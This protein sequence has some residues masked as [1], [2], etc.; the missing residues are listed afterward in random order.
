MRIYGGHRA[1][2]YRSVLCWAVVTVVVLFKWNREEESDKYGFL[3]VVII[4][5]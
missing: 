5:V 1:I 2:I 3:F 4:A